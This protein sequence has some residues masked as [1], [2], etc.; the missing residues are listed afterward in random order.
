MPKDA[1]SN[2]GPVC[3]TDLEKEATK[4]ISERTLSYFEGGADEELTLKDN[5]DAFR[6]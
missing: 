1:I 4:N 2:S 3:L 5:I 6:R